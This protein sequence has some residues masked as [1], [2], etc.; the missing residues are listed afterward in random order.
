MKKKLNTI[1]LSL[2]KEVKTDR[3]KM[4][5]IQQGLAAGKFDLTTKFLVPLESLVTDL[6]NEYKNI[7][8]LLDFLSV[9]TI[10]V[11]VVKNGN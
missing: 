4:R 3:K 6:S 11:K 7:A 10:F 1:S 8:N 9:R 5:L 2:S